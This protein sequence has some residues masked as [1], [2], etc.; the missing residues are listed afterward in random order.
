[1]FFKKI[2]LTTQ[3]TTSKSFSHR[4]LSIRMLILDT[5]K[6]V[7]N[8]ALERSTATL[9]YFMRPSLWSCW[10]SFWRY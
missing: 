6:P 3:K 1:M 4:V 2:I 7:T 9:I 5:A 10:P 8:F